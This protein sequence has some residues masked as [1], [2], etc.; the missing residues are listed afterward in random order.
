[1]EWMYEGPS[2]TVNRDDYLTG[3]KIDKNFELYGSNIK[4]KPSP[5]DVVCEKQTIAPKCPGT[6]LDIYTIKNQDPLV[7][8]KVQEERIRRDILDN[9]I[10]LKRLNRIVMK[11]LAK[12]LKRMQ[13]ECAAS[14][15]E[16]E[17]E[18]PPD[19]HNK[20]K[21][22]H[23][24]NRKRSG[25]CHEKRK[26]D[27]HSQSTSKRRRRPSIS[28]PQ[29]GI[30]TN[31]PSSRSDTSSRNRHRRSEARRGTNEEKESS[32]ISS[33]DRKNNITNQASDG[34]RPGSIPKQY[35]LA[36]SSS[37]A[38]EGRSSFGASATPGEKTIASKRKKLSAAEI[39]QRR[40]EM[41]DNARWRQEERARNLSRC[42]AMEEKLDLAN[43]GPTAAR[44]PGFI[45]KL[46]QKGS[47]DGSLEKRIKSKVQT[48]QRSSN[49][50]ETNFAKK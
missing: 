6:I 19:K 14:S 11:T 49:V 44:A 18:Q 13:K 30:S 31:K 43:T 7:S 27:D 28:E 24:D 4:E 15:D 22:R 17:E 40:K 35:R 9:P 46:V 25:S 1:M 8:I 48:I 23:H 32:V 45:Q 21:S 16:E 20:N 37:N 10:K 41:L 3:R 38:S 34:H 2:S 36:P 39:E 42:S 47:E 33:H 12:K 29:S 5:I 50:M 26:S